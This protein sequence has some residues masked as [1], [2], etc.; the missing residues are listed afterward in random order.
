MVLLCS[1]YPIPWLATGAFEGVTGIEWKAGDNLKDHASA[2][3]AQTLRGPCLMAS[4]GHSDP[5]LGFH[6][7]P[8]Q[9]TRGDQH[10]RDTQV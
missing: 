7:E 6:L 5:A 3:Q 2:F 9:G 8:G 4:L 10:H 1:S